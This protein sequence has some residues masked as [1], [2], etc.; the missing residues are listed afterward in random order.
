M[1]EEI[2]HGTTKQ[3][4]RPNRIGLC[5]FAFFMK[6]LARSAPLINVAIDIKPAAVLANEAACFVL[7]ARSTAGF[8]SGYELD[9]GAAFARFMS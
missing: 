8:V 4:F 5:L 7:L 9:N 1:P 2:N 3:Y 6:S